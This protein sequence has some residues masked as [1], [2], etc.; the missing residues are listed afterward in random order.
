MAWYD[1]PIG[2]GYD[3]KYEGRGT[4]TP[5]FA[6]DVETPYDTPI[7]T[8]FEG[9][10]TKADYADWG[11]EVFIETN[12]PGIGPIKEYFYHLDENEVVEGQHVTR[13]EEIG[14]S[15]GQSGYGRHPVHNTSKV[16]WSTGPHTH[17]GFFGG[18]WVPVP[19]SGGLQVPSGPDITPWLGTGGGPST[20]GNGFDVGAL[21]LT[22]GPKGSQKYNNC[23]NSLNVGDMP[24]CVDRSAADAA[25]SAYRKAHPDKKLSCD[26]QYAGGF[27]NPANVLCQAEKSV[28]IESNTDLLYR[29]GFIGAGILFIIFGL[30]IF[31]KGFSPQVTVGA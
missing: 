22:C 14:R 29:A 6:D 30:V 9:D 28:G 7:T 3:P 31:G 11:G 5:H 13:G 27:L 10:V 23:V 17:V 4:D 1:Y 16:T 24:S 15:G 20:G 26:E 19:N 2:H 12:V 21:C 25:F 18:T 8:L